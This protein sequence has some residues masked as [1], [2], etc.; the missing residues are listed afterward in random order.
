MIFNYNFY[1]YISYDISY[2][3]YHYISYD[4]LGTVIAP[5]FF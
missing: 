3:F 1:H 4:L 5:L 2:N